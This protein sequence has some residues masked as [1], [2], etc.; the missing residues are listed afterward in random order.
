MRPL[1][2]VGN[3]GEFWTAA[4]PPWD[5]LGRTATGFSSA[6]HAPRGTRAEVTDKAHRPRQCE[7]GGGLWRQVWEPHASPDNA[8]LTLK[9][10]GRTQDGQGGEIPQQSLGCSHGV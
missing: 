8:V 7:Q 5:L 3:T 1:K 6:R 2:P 10:K 9:E 4:L